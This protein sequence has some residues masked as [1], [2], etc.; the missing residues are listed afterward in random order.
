MIV[1]VGCRPETVRSKF[2]PN[3]GVTQIV[4]RDCC[5]RT[6]SGHIFALS[7]LSP[8]VRRHGNLADTIPHP[9]NV[10]TS[11][12]RRRHWRCAPRASLPTLTALRIITG[13]SPWHGQVIILTS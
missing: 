8:A 4:V 2:G 10:D 12:D 5:R 6:L 11:V 1:K 9:V 13:L 7:V 3:P